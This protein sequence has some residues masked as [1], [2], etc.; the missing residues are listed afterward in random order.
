MSGG[1]QRRSGAIDAVR[2][3][4][5]AVVVAG[6]VW[7][8]VP[9]FR[10]LTYSWHV[11][12]FF[13]LSGYL[14]TRSTMWKLTRRRAVS[15]LLPYASWLVLISLLIPGI[16]PVPN[17]VLGGAYL[18]RPYSAF[19]FVTALF[20]A[21]ILAAVLDGLALRWQWA[22]AGALLVGAYLVGPEL[23]RVPL[24][25]G[26]G[27]ACVVF[28]IAGRTLRRVRP[29]IAG[30]GSV[31]AIA[32]VGGLA[33]AGLGLVRPLDLKVADFGTPVASV[34]VAVM[35]SAGLILVAE[36]A[37]DGASVPVS[38]VITRVSLGG[39]M[40]VLTHA[41]VLHWIGFDGSGRVAAFAAALLIPWIAALIVLVT[42]LA[43]P[44]TGVRRQPVRL[45]ARTPQR[46]P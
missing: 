13:V 25:A 19:W 1:T 34:L 7:G 42:P 29:M 33:L 46:V 43:L 24:D 35:I 39:F 26:V 45:V 4:G 11:P 8:D 21:V 40:V 32:L 28:V 18:S 5:V 36:V 15:L 2:V 27:V 17:L 10:A 23:A 37:L 12:V 41:A 3:L 38:A 20:V 16:A 22:I 44:L 6:H 14:T 30:A 9:Q 31:G